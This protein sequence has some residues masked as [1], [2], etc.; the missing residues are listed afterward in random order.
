M[1]DLPLELV[2]VHP[3]NLVDDSDATVIWFESVSVRGDDSDA[4]TCLVLIF[5]TRG[6]ELSRLEAHCR[7][8]QFVES[9]SQAFRIDP[10]R[11]ELPER[12]VRSSGFGDVRSLQEA[13]TRIDCR[14][15]EVRHIR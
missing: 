10:G 7:Q 14:G 13:Q 5:R 11:A 9:L 15:F 2:G 4:V 12:F 3:V 8:I 1:S 6:R